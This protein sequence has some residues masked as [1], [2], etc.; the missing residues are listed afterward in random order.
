MT[1]PN[2]IVRDLFPVQESARIFSMLI[3]ILSISPIL[4][5]TAGG[6]VT[7]HFHWSVVFW[8]LA[9]LALLMLYA[10]YR[11]LPESG[12]PDKTISMSPSSILKAYR[13]VL[14]ERQFVIYALAGSIAAA[15][16]FT[17]ISGS[18][19]VFM[20]LYGVSEQHYGWIFSAIAAGLISASQLNNLLLKR[21]SSAQLLRVII[22]LQSIIGIVLVVGTM[23][24]SL[25]L[26]PMFTLLFLFLS[27]QGFTFPNAASMA[28]APFSKGA[29][30]ASAL[31][32]A[33][34]MAFGALCS[35]LVGLFFNGTAL[36]MVAIMAACSIISSAILLTAKR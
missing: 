32:G 10:V 12:H 3:L 11:G 1:A 31:M 33:L 19:F 26:Y 4:A 17:Y 15:S 5:P 7:A 24:G 22:P 25:G 8:I 28:M 30:S 18:P 14:G 35:S 23:M 29:G 6:F 27:C 36:P 34:Q 20:K 2:A 9:V 21:R 13:E 16:L